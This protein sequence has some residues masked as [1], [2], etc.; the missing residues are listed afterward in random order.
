VDGRKNNGGRREGA[1]R[2][3][4][5]DELALVE[6]LS[7]LD[8][9]AFAELQKGVKSGDFQFIKLFMEYRFGRPKQVIDNNVSMA[10][11]VI[12]NWN[13]DSIQSDSETETGA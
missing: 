12:I 2:K 8:D 7:P 10:E 13:A 5:A 4:K 11:P 9:I 1:G 6:R 3:P